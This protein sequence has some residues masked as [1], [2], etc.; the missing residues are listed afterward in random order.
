MSWLED[1]KREVD[2]KMGKEEYVP[3]KITLEEAE[4]IKGH[5]KTAITVTGEAISKVET[6]EPDAAHRLIQLAH[7][8]LRAAAGL[9]GFT[10]ER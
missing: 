10:P 1:A 2:R 5:L 6:D 8:S 3:I 7:S 4:E 9:L